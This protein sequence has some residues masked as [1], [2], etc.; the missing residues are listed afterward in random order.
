MKGSGGAVD[1]R[2]MCEEEGDGREEDRWRAGAE[3]A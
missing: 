3:G 1:G 2:E